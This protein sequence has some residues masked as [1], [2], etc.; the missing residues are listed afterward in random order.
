MCLSDLKL[1][2]YYDG[3]LPKISAF[4]VK[5]HLK[6]CASCRAKLDAYSSLSTSLKFKEFKPS[7]LSKQRVY[8]QVMATINE[9]NKTTSFNGALWSK[10]VAFVVPLVSGAAVVGLF[11]GWLLFYALSAN[12][13]SE[14][15]F[16]HVSSIAIN[17]SNSSISTNPSS[18]LKNSSINNKIS[19]SPLNGEVSNST[20]SVYA[21]TQEVPSSSVVVNESPTVAHKGLAVS[22][23]TNSISHYNREGLYNSYNN[24]QERVFSKESLLNYGTTTVEFEI[25]SDLSF[26]T[27]GYPDFEVLP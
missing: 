27:S 9:G 1:S 22:S 23:G 7:S 5:R 14:V 11:S 17:D 26:S 24:Y 8:N 12:S 10:K 6:G 21:N 3:Q 19:D 25:P 15:A 2:C 4:F 18:A 20:L 16:N 13:K